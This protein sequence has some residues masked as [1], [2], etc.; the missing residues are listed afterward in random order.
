MGV[1]ASGSDL[2]F[3]TVRRLAV[4]VVAIAAVLGYLYG[5]PAS[6]SMRDAAIAECNEHAN[7]NYRSFR[8]AWEVGVLPHWSCSDASRPA[9]D[10]V[11]LGWWTSPF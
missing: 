9:E 1:S 3:A 11:S 8:L 7:G 10:A 6:P 5:P 4:A 2:T